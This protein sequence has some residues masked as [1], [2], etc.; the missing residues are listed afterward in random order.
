MDFEDDLTG[1]LLESVHELDPPVAAMVAEGGRAG[2]QR[3]RIRRG[4]QTA[5]AAAMVA[6]LVTVGAVVT[7]R[8][9][10]SQSTA[11]SA[12][13][14][15][16]SPPAGTA[17]AATPTAG[18]SASA[19]A[20]PSTGATAAAEPATADLSWQAMLKILHDQLPPGGQLAKLNTFA[21]KFNTGPQR[22]YVELQYN[23]GAGPST[24]M[25]DVSD[26]PPPTMPGKPGAPVP[27][28]CANWMG[29]TDE[30]HDRKPGYEHPTCQERQLPDGT[31]VFS[32][33]TGTDG[34]GLYDE[35]VKVSRPDG[36]QVSITAANATLDQVAAGPGITVTR[37][38]PPVGLP[39]WEAIALSPQWQMKI[40]QSLADAG[41]AYART[42]TRLP[43]P[44]GSKPADCVID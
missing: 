23:D 33:I 26:A 32:Y 36:T 39:G 17:P 16:P 13:S 44:Q 19:A 18:A 40:P 43:C 37:D 6:A 1:M 30:G 24:V 27:L 9:G 15:S 20:S 42:V 8:G 12:V 41:V 31:K 5:G 28:T 7:Q 2:R 4:L 21:V 35:A 25:L 22:R 34:Y 11:A 14:A 38:K 10:S 3:R 29:G